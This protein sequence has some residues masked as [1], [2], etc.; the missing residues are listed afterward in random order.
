M[1]NEWYT[2]RSAPMAF[3][4]CPRCCKRFPE[5]TCE[6]CTNGNVPD[7]VQVVLEGLV[8]AQWPPWL[9]DRFDCLDLNSA[10]VLDDYEL[11]PPDY[12]LPPSRWYTRC[13][14]SFWGSGPCNFLGVKFEITRSDDKCL[15][16][17]ML[18]L[19]GE[20]H[21]FA[22]TFEPPFDCLNFTDESLSYLSWWPGSVPPYHRCV[23]ASGA[24][25]IV[26]AL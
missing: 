20:I 10:Y 11:L 16:Q 14:W 12:T 2:R 3:L 7:A 13:T 21:T 25:A 24:V 26:S 22:K 4:P 6:Y 19:K 5:H 17:V 8:E 9:C 1:P 18:H 15:L 23:D